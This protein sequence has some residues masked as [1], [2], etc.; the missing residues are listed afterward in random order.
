[1]RFSLVV[2]GVFNLSGGVREILQ[3][4]VVPML[5]EVSVAR[6][7]ILTASSPV[8][9]F[10]AMMMP[11]AMSMT[12]LWSRAAGRSSTWSSAAAILSPTRG[13]RAAASLGS[14]ACPVSGAFVSCSPSLMWIAQFLG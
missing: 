12:I 14:V 8:Q 5:T 3:G 9:W 13:A 7:S 10:W 1:M 4:N 6:G 11:R 2:D